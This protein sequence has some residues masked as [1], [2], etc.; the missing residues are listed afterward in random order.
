MHQS[1][2][3]YA[4]VHAQSVDQYD[5]TYPMRSWMRPV[6]IGYANAM[7]G[8]FVA[9]SVH[10]EQLELAGVTAP[11]HVVSLPYDRLAAQAKYVRY[12]HRENAVIYTSRLDQEKDPQFMMQVASKFL[13]RHPEWEWWVTTS[14]AEFRSYNNPEAVRELKALARSNPRF[15]LFKGLSKQAYHDM[16]SR[17]RIQFNSAKQDY[18]SWTLIE[19]V[20]HECWPVYPAFRSFPECLPVSSLYSAGSVQ[21]ALSRLMHAVNQPPSTQGL[22]VYERILSASH[23]GLHAI[24]SIVSS[25]HNPCARP[26]NVWDAEPR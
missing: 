9:S 6:E 22:A 26:A 16:L 23:F 4:M 14:G 15:K 24:A 12:R 5:F 17:A 10:K 8:L 3:I 7:C 21:S 13:E 19:A 1:L 18:V 11:I 20:H 2:R 25:P